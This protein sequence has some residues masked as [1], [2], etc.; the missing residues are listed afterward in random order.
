MDLFT[1]ALE[2]LKV[3]IFS[4]GGGMATLPFLADIAVR[5]PWFT[6]EQLIDM[7]AISESTPGPIGINIATFAG[8]SAGG[9]L[10][11]IV[12][13]ICL[14]IPSMLIALIMSG[15]LKKFNDNKFVKWGFYGLRPAVTALIAFAAYGIVIITFFNFPLY[16]E[17]GN[18]WDMFNVISLGIFAFLFVFTRK[19]KIHPAF[20]LGIAAV[21]GIIFKL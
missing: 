8:Y 11:S 6:P 12:S 3:G 21:L 5:K 17:T 2:F 4:I 7:I 1:L 13:S 16:Q 20:Y 15:V 19:V 9:V 10:G 14:I 18:L